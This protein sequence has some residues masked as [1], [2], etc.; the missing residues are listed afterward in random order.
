MSNIDG[1]KGFS[2]NQ[3]NKIVDIMNSSASKTKEEV[4]DSVA[5][6]STRN[7][8]MDVIIMPDVKVM[9]GNF[10]VENMASRVKEEGIALK[11][12]LELINGVTAK[13]TPEEAEKLQKQGFLVYDDS[14]KD[15]SPGIPAATSSTTRAGNPWDM[16]EIKDIEWTGAK[17]LHDQGL[18]GK[19]RTV[20]VI[21]SGYNHPAKPLKAWADVVE[22]SPKPIDPNGHGTHVAGDVNKIAPDA[23]LVGVRVMNSQGQGRP[24]DIVKGIEWVIK[25]KDR[26]GIDII[27]MSLGAGPDGVPFYMD[28]INK[29]V[30][31]A[32]KF[33]ID[34][35]VAA[36]NSGPGAETIGSP[37]DDPAA[38]TIGAAL[39]PT[40]VSDFSSRGPTEDNL[41]KPDI[42]APGEFIT[43]WAAPDSQLDNIGKT[44]QTIRDMTP[45]QLTTLFTNKPDLIKALGLPSNVMSL[46]PKERETVVK[47]NLPPMFKP[48]ADT[49]AGPGTSFASPEVAGLAALLKQAVP[50]KTP[51]D[52]KEAFMKTADSMGSQY[53]KVDQ[54]SGFVD[55]DEAVKYLKEHK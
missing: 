49:L 47:T 1:V 35:V 33:G 54:G 19:G 39:N 50:D 15:L 42:I 18:T 55:A 12:N 43:S 40:K 26:F 11:D 6:G 48:T 44:V 30:E 53:K 10:S 4:V 20:A 27:N 32:I 45:D 38:L 3:L 41:E 28:P 13:V 5:L 25:N 17:K 31:Q 9:K 24:S 2:F 22:K 29:A 34:V 36:G 14:P 21:D 23:E 16:P 7:P 37:A 46:S 52:R 51:A 8:Q